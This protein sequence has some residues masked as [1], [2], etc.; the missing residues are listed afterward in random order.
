MPQATRPPSTRSFTQGTADPEG[1]PETPSSETSIALLQRRCSNRKPRRAATG[2]PEPPSSAASA[3]EL[4]GVGHPPNHPEGRPVGVTGPTRT[5]SERSP[6]S[7]TRALEPAP[8]RVPT[9]RHEPA[10]LPPASPRPEGP[11]DTSF[12]SR[13]PSRHSESRP[14]SPQRD[15]LGSARTTVASRPV[16]LPKPGDRDE[17]FDLD[18]LG[19]NRRPP[20]QTWTRRPLPEESGSQSQP[21]MTSPP[22]PPPP[23][24]EGDNDGE[25]SDGV[26]SERQDS[27][28]FQSFQPLDPEGSRCLELRRA[29]KPGA[30]EQK[31]SSSR[32]CRHRDPERPWRFELRRAVE[33]S[34]RRIRITSSAPPTRRPAQHRT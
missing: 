26:R 31:P 3:S 18:S 29:S 15:Q 28:A 8:R 14:T 17:S 2:S 7:P 22:G 1:P 16:P 27:T 34:A 5:P 11:R 23:P 4:D 25:S 10:E 30:R 13:V 6:L 12:R 33:P 19:L 21:S 24:P 20:S 9:L 32:T